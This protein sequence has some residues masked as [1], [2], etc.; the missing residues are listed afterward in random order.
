MTLNEWRDEVWQLMEAKGFHDGRTNTRDDVMVRL[1]LV[2]T[3]VSEAVQE[4]KRHWTGCGSSAV[5]AMVAE[6]VADALIRLFDLCGCLGIDVD[7]AVIAKHSKNAGRP[8]NYGTPN[9]ETTK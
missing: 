1:C 7:A 9:Q 5:R 3:E 6:E 2:H 8:R 4:V